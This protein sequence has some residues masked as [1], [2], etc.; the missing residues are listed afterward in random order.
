MD[1]FDCLCSKALTPHPI[2]ALAPVDVHVVGPAWK[3]RGGCAT[4]FPR[5]DRED[6]ALARLPGCMQL[7]SPVCMP[8]GSTPRRAAFCRCLLHLWAARC[9]AV[10]LRMERKQLAGYGACS[11]VLA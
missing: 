7:A 5:D 9:A 2:G 3:V 10:L 11:Q 1:I 8:R 4:M 6:G